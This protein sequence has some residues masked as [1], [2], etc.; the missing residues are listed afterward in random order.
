MALY[1]SYFAN[2]GIVKKGILN[3]ITS[4]F[5]QLMK[6]KT[7]ETIANDITKRK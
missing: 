1:G 3:R 6:L 4:A 5:V 7:T 2:E